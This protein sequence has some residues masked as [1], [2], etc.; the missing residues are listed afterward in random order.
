MLIAI[1]LILLPGGKLLAAEA[2][3][4]KLH[5][6]IHLVEAQDLFPPTK[7]DCFIP[8]RTEVVKP[9]SD[10]G[11]RLDM[12]CAI[13]G[14]ITVTE[15]GARAAF[16]HAKIV[17]RSKLLKS[18]SDQLF[19]IH[20]H[21]DVNCREMTR[22]FTH[23]WYMNRFLNASRET[24]REGA[25]EAISWT[26]GVYAESDREWSR[27]ETVVRALSPSEKYLCSKWESLK[28]KRFY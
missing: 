4:N 21:E 16:V 25:Q 1:F 9:L 3:M 6:G 17:W 18:D 8:G 13:P 7:P 27:W 14:T 26:K 12:E 10:D 24:G 2:N 22:R 23:D 15:H 19:F 20:S 11:Y 5:S 28:N